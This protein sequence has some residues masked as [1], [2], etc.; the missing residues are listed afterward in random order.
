MASSKARSEVGVRVMGWGA[1]LTGL[2]AVSVSRTRRTSTLAGDGGGDQGGAV[3]VDVD[4][5]TLD[6]LLSVVKPANLS[7][8]IIN[9]PR[10]LLKVGDC[11][12]PCRGAR[13][14]RPLASCSS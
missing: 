8:D 3:F 12:C 6:S 7:S 4:D 9:D 13:E 14:A 10:L 5:G 1:G 2:G 11:D